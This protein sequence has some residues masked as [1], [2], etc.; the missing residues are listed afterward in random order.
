MSQPINVVYEPNFPNAFS[1]SV[2]GKTD[3][4]KNDFNLPEEVFYCRSLNMLNV[5]ASLKHLFN[6]MIL[7]VSSVFI[8]FTFKFNQIAYY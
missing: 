6:H 7:K 3:V 1:Y 2:W 5:V 4:T 8:S